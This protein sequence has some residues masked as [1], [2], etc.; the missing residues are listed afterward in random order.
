[1]MRISLRDAG[2]AAS[3]AFASILVSCGKTTPPPAAKAPPSSGGAAAAIAKCERPDTT[4]MCD[5]DGNDFVCKLS[6]S[7]VAG[8]ITVDPY[9]LKL[10]AGADKKMTITWELTDPAYVFISGDGPQDIKRTNGSDASMDHSAHGDHDNGKRY[11]VKFHPQHES[12]EWAYTMQVRK[13]ATDDE[14]K[15]G[16]T[17]KIYQCDPYFNNQGN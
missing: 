4:G 2:L 6:V 14:K 16:G 17:D 11:K 8:K 10:P 7:V 1:M 9:K 3:L 15:Q 5:P 13:L 12:Q